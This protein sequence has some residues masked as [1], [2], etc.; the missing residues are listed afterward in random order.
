MKDQAEQNVFRITPDLPCAVTHTRPGIDQ[1]G[2]VG[3]NANPHPVGNA[4]CHS[5]G[6]W[7]LGCN[8]NRHRVRAIQARSAQGTY[9]QTVTGKQ[10]T[11]G[12][13]G[14]FQRLHRGGGQAVETHRRVADAERAAGDEARVEEAGGF[15]ERQEVAPIER[16][17]QAFAVQDGIV[18]QVP[19]M[20]DCSL[21]GQNLL[22]TFPVIEHLQGIFVYFGNPSKP[23]PV[24]FELPYEMT[25][26]DWGGFL[27]SA[28]WKVNQQYIWDNLN[29]PM[30]ALAL[31]GG[32]FTHVVSEVSD[33][34]D[35]ADTDCGFLLRRVTGSTTSFETMEYVDSGA[36][37]W[38][39]DVNYPAA[40]G[41]G[42]MLRIV[43]FVTPIDE[44]Q[45]V[46]NF[47]RLREV[48]GWRRD[49]WYFL[50]KAKLEDF[51]WQVL[52]Q[53]REILE[54]MPPWPP[55]ENLYQHDMGVTRMR[56]LAR[57]EAEAQ[58]R[59]QISALEEPVAAS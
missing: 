48:S 11:C 36:Q 32:T 35:V 1:I 17:R 23:E 47:W 10:R 18:A 30:H 7:P 39:F 50:Y 27:V 13:S 29:D 15:G 43:C 26:E 2:W 57:R 31:H 16:T 4:P 24:A 14:V 54:L 28:R 45:S 3:A 38:R 33:Q 34:V 58:V 44:N 52:E 53:D 41:P 9:V 42:G 55:Q 22:K 12:S 6:F 20:P 25:S 49:L 8:P 19:A 5:Q 59:A 56:R 51:S 46:I 40:A 37:F 21:V